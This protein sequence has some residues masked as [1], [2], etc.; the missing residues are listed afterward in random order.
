MQKKS[1]KIDKE[2]YD[3]LLAIKQNT[4]CKTIGTVI[5]MLIEW[6]HV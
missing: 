1:I 6:K 4:G 3:K 5:R 2:V